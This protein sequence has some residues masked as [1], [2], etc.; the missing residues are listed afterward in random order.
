MGLFNK[1]KKHSE[2]ESYGW[3]S[4]TAEFERIYPGQKDPKHYGT[5]IS[6]DLGG[7]DPLRGISIYDDKDCLHFVSYGLSELYEKKS[8]NPDVSGYGMELTFRLKKDCYKNEE[9]EI[10]CI[11]GILQSIARITFTKGEIF[12]PYEYIYTGQKTGI[13]SERKSAITGFITVPDVKA[14]SIETKNGKVDF[15]ELVGVKDVELQPLL[16]KE[17]TAKDLYESLKT[18]IT[19][20]SR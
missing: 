10:K 18:D 4:I 1:K 11:C 7:N 9:N 15:T 2:A 17:M 13:D 6:W 12:M 16:K 3:D 5:I 19:D 14:N 8:E 20:Y